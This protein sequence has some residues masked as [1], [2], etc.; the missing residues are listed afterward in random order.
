M[1]VIDEEGIKKIIKA[2][3]PCGAFLIYGDEPY[4]KK[5]YAQKLV[6]A[7]VNGSMADFNLHK[8]EGADCTAEDIA[9][10]CESLPVMS[11][12][13]VVFVRNLNFDALNADDTELISA[14]I[15][16]LPETT[17]FVVWQDSLNFSQKSSAKAAKIIKLFEKYG[18]AVQISKRTGASLLKPMIAGA[19]KRGCRL[20]NAA[21]SYLVSVVGDDYNT[22]FNELEKLCHYVGEGDITKQIIDSVCVKSV[23][24]TAFDLV[25]AI[26]SGNPDRAS[27]LLGVLFTRKVEPI[28]IMGALINAYV[29]MYR[30]KVALVG[31]KNA[32]YF[33]GYFNYKNKEF[34]LRNAARDS[35]KLSIEQLRKSLDILYKADMTLKTEYSGND[36]R[37]LAIE[38]AMVRLM[39]AANGQ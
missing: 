30:A 8:F 34:R 7:G 6:N 33:A 23:E 38:K 31:G 15:T 39:L 25:K 36:G 16:N 10:A 28:I 9:D 4:L 19:A 14:E 1:A 27:Y 22:I 12:C 13:S 18:Y 24:A 29:D 3:S 35:S 11:A 21:A 2:G 20:D 17:L 5:L 37:R 32:E 26:V